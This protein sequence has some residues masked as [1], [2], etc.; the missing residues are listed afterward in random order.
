MSVIVAQ[1]RHPKSAFEMDAL[2]HRAVT[3]RDRAGHAQLGQEL[4]ALSPG[5]LVRLLVVLAAVLGALTATL[6]L[7]AAFA[8]TA[9]TRTAAR[10]TL[11]LLLRLV[12]WYTPRG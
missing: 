1:A 6:A 4:H 3:L 5:Y 12:P 9:T 7:A 2:P 8:S 10:N 11:D